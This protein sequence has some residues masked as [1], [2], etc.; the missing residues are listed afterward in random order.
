MQSV[1]GGAYNGKRK[2]VKESLKQSGIGRMFW[3]EG[4]I[5]EGPFSK[6]DY[7]II[8][9]FEKLIPQYDLSEDEIVAEVLEELKRL[10]RETN[11]I[12]ICTDIGRGIVPLSKEERHLRDTCGR[13][14]QK[15]FELSEKVIRVWYGIPEILKGDSCRLAP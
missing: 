9:G 11:L 7:V 14:Y 10:D 6:K 4:E 5:P 8:G 1:I 3:Y 12:C 2:F 15:L 13:L